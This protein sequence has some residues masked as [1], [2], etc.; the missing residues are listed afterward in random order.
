MVT[1]VGKKLLST[2]RKTFTDVRIFRTAKTL[3]SVYITGGTGMGP[4]K[5]LV[6][7]AK[8]VAIDV[9]GKDNVLRVYGSPGVVA[10]GTYP[11][12]SIKIKKGI[13]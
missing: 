5:T 7:K 9:C 10:F 8:K 1:E 12:I 6:S 2:L 11:S 4:S 3:D 13:V